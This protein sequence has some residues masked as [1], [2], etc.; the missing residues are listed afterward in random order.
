MSGSGFTQLDL[1]SP[2]AAAS[3]AEAAHGLPDDCDRYGTCGRARRVIRAAVCG[4]QRASGWTTRQSG[5]ADTWLITGHRGQRTG[6]G[7]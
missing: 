2:R 3:P 6:A 5:T 7:R 1:F 4:V